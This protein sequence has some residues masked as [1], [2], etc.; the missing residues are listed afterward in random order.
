MKRKEMNPLAVWVTVVITGLLVM[1]GIDDVSWG[2][3]LDDACRARCRQVADAASKDKRGL[4]AAQAFGACMDSCKR[5][6]LIKTEADIPEFCK[7]TCEDALKRM[8]RNGTPAQLKECVDQCVAITT[9]KLRK[10][11][12]QQ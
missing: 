3:Q 8:N 4:P 1:G 6:A 5:L 9:E 12:P 11:K 2:D 10:G 7:G